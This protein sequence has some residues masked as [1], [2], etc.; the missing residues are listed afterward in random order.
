MATIRRNLLAV[1]EESTIS[2][3]VVTSF[4]LLLVAARKS[5]H[6]RPRPPN[7]LTFHTVS[8]CKFFSAKCTTIFLF[9]CPIIWVCA[10][11][12][13]PSQFHCSSIEFHALFQT[14][15]NFF[16]VHMNWFVSKNSKCKSI[17]WRPLFQFYYHFEVCSCPRSV[18]LFWWL[19]VVV[20]LCASPRIF[21]KSR[22]NTR[23]AK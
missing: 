16:Q 20:V 11:K 4:V 6:R 7:T 23:I 12:K 9:W 5:H 15:P 17:R 22:S 3:L 14:F 10:K 2:S 19:V 1:I 8:T 21:L 18:S 13:Q